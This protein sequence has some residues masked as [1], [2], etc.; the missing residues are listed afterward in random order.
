[1]RIC[2]TIAF[3][4]CLITWPILF[5]INATGKGGGEGLNLLTFGNVETE[6]W[7][8]RN[9][10]FAHALVG[11]IFYAFVMI[12]ICRESIFYINLRQA[13]LLSPI[14]SHRISS[15]TVLFVSVPEPY[16]HESKL[17]KVFGKSVKR[18]WI[19]RETK[20]LDELVQERDKVA[21]KL[22]GA[23]TKLIKL[24]NKERLAQIKKNKGAAA[25][26]Q[27]QPVISHADAES[28][29]LAARWVPTKKRPT[30][31]TGKFGLYGPKVDTINWCRERLETLIP[32]TNA[33]QQT[34]RSGKAPG[35]G[36]VFIEF[37]E[38]SDAQTAYQTLSHH[39][40]LH[41]SPK[42]IGMHP[43]EIV[44][45]S[46][47]VSWWQRVLRRYVVVGI[48]AALILFW[49]IPVAG[50]GAISNV[51]QLMKLS[52]L[53]WLE[54]VPSQIIGVISGLLPSVL[55]SVLMSLVPIIMRILAKLSGEPTLARV[56][57]FTQNAYFAFQ[58]IQVFL[59][60]TLGSGAA[61]V[62]Q[63]IADNPGGTPAL[64]ASKLPL[65]SNFYISYFILQGLTLASGVVS[66]VVGFILFNL[67]YKFF[68][69]TPRSM[70]NRWTNLSA[71][72]WGSVLPVYANIVVIGMYQ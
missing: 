35:V 46:L 30:H 11:W 64:L 68:T 27:Q 71:I 48:I 66:Q 31:R 24:A 19:T 42:Y 63:D 52:W 25:D 15:K 50:V 62:A 55:L 29:S 39:Q 56:E 1:M 10:L 17:R 43:D 41:M 34:Y 28:G 57:L 58:V 21:F 7:N 54:K 4:G 3:V 69:S 36:A 9:K 14:Y 8:G 37:N 16:L 45:A 67:F 32:E 2:A 51:P 38:Q 59:V 49:A 60:V 6:T 20:K 44:W 18:V 22:E 33:A 23:E 53:T 12:M 40:A 13:F 26:E 70:Y 65:A 47:K 72:S 61:A 5:P